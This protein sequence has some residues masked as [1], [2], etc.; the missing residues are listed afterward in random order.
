MSAKDFLNNKN[1]TIEAIECYDKNLTNGSIDL[2][3]LL[4]E[5]AQSKVNVAL[6]SIGK[7]LL[8]IK[9]KKK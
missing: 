3:A 7:R 1:Y 6:G 9:K 4:E 8:I 5:Y 2:V